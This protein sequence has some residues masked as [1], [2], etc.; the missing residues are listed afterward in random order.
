MTTEAEPAKTHQIF[1]TKL[2]LDV[3]R[4]EIEDLFDRYGNILDVH[5][6]KSY[7]FVVVWHNQAI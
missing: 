4:Q 6:K 1:V 2:P 3:T 5:I 7:V